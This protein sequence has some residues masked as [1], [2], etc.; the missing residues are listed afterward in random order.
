MIIG[1]GIDLVEIRRIND[2]LKRKSKNL[3]RIFTTFEI[4]YSQSK[5]NPAE[6]FAARFVA[7]EAFLKAIGTGWGVRQSPKWHEIEIVNTKTNCPILK[8]HGKANSICNRLKIKKLHL[9]LT[10]T[11]QYALA[12]VLLEGK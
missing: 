7:K 2:L 11:K 5:A 3:S 9:S 10:H 4:T 1:V 6:S 8:L 12:V